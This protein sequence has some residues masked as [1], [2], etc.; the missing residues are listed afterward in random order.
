M[1]GET[2]ETDVRNGKIVRLA[3]LNSYSD[4]RGEKEKSRMIL[5]YLH[6]IDWQ[7]EAA[8][9]LDRDKGSRVRLNRP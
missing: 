1:V 6:Q 2:G 5:N 9:S 7:N 4:T 8:I 3:R